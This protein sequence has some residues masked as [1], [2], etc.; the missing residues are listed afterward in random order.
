MPFT[1]SPP[2]HIKAGVSVKSLMW[3]RFIV[4]LPVCLA[5]IYLFGFPAL[6]NLIAG[7]LGAV[8]IELAIQKTFK[9][10]VTIGDG[11]AAYLGLL[12]ALMVPP[13]VPFWMPFIAAVFGVGVVKHAFG[14]LGSYM[15]HPALAAWV[16]LKLSWT[17]TMVPASIPQLGGFSD[18]IIENGA[19]FLVDASPIAM[20]GVLYL[21]ARKYIE[22]RIPLTYLLTTVLLV[23]LLG[24][25]LSYVF[26]GSFLLG[27]FFIATETSTSPITRNGRLV[28]GIACGFL[29]VIY[30]YFTGN[31]IE[32]TF[33]G[34]LLA[35]AISPLIE[36]STLPKPFGGVEA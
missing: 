10:R 19:G 33:Y 31:Y 27:V 15:F 36:R 28:Y 5:S 2:P 29:T 23:V 7:V 6:G 11:N 8:F 9:Q 26:T 30:G 16:F 24:D 1:V 32:G 35:N 4:L 12:I 34:L 25:P 14:G 13:T 22:W 17:Q 21:I 20:I 18:L 3:S